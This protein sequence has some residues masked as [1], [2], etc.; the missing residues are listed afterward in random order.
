MIKLKNISKYKQGYSSNMS[1]FKNDLEGINVENNVSD[2]AGIIDSRYIKKIDRVIRDIE[3]KTTIEVAVITIDSLK[4][5]PIDKFALRLLN[6]FGVG[7]KDS[8]N[9]ILILLSKDDN[10]FRIEVGLGLEGIVTDD[11]LKYLKDNF[12]LTNFKQKKFGRGILKFVD[13][14]ADKVSEGKFSRLSIISI[15]AGILS[16]IYSLITW[17]SLLI[18]YLGYKYG[19]YPFG[20]SV[21]RGLENLM[22]VSVWWIYLSIWILII[23]VSI[24]TLTAIICGSVDLLHIKAGISETGRRKLDIAGIVLAVSPIVA[25]GTFYIPAVS[26]LISMIPG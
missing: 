13:A 5:E 21:V 19:V 9:G 15:T 2:F 23:F 7:K 22:V 8:N 12:I 11:I 24:P 25:I 26:R 3:S 1:D 18:L 17:I 6:K 20:T 14:V 10:K 16:G 4:G